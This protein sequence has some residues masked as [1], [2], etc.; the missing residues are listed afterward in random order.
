MSL[1]TRNK[2][3]VTGGMSSM[4][5]LVF[6]LLIFFIIISTLV[7]NGVNVDLPK[8][9]GTTSVTPNLTLSM[10][11][12]GTYHLNGGGSIPQSDLETKLK[13]EMDKQDEKVIYLQADANVPTGQTVEIIG[14]AKA[15]Q[16]KVMLGS[17]PKN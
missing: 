3:N 9:K 13:I 1:S 8:S 16:W 10:T 7:S 2:I 11:A 4:T 6:L 14:L 17:S 15:N 12:E 5:D